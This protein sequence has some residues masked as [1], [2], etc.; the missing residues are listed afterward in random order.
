MP[1]GR[2][3]L[4]LA[5]ISIFASAC[6]SAKSPSSSSG[7]VVVI[8]GSCQ[9]E[10]GSFADSAYVAY[11]RGGAL[12]TPT[13]GTKRG[14][15]RLGES[16]VN[17][18]LGPDLPLTSDGLVDGTVALSGAWPD[19]A[20]L[21]SRR[22]TAMGKQLVVNEDRRMFV[23]RAGQWRSVDVS[24]GMNPGVVIGSEKGSIVFNDNEATWLSEDADAATRT[25]PSI[26]CAE[27]RQQ[28]FRSAASRGRGVVVVA[29]CTAHPGSKFPREDDELRIVWWP[30]D[31]PE[32]VEIVPLDARWGGADDVLLGGDDKRFVAVASGKDARIVEVGGDGRLHVLPS[33]F[34]RAVRS[35]AVEDAVAFAV[36]DDGELWSQRADGQLA[37]L[38]M[39]TIDGAR[40]D[41]EEV[42]CGNGVW[43]SGRLVEG[44]TPV[45]H[46]VVAT[47]YPSRPLRCDVKENGAVALQSE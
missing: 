8:Y 46:A 14:I 42:V 11:G 31:A 5:L 2:K 33:G 29:A 24:V 30:A 19:N 28:K 26:G 18:P 43:V 21:Y 15:A 38:P 17:L 35:L 32:H 45:G 40:F 16:V 10:I 9:L 3:F 36:T 4:R 39:P 12:G 22:F 27:G 13:V 47:R 1:P 7:A 41:A 37:A 44:A 25:L 20:W 34:G 23:H 6:P